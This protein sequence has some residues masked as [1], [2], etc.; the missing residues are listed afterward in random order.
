MQLNNINCINVATSS[1]VA[2]LT[3]NVNME[4][5]QVN[6]WNTV[7]MARFSSQLLGSF[8]ING[9]TDSGAGSIPTRFGERLGPHAIELWKGLRWKKSKVFAREVRCAGADLMHDL[10]RGILW[11][12]FKPAFERHSPQ[13]MQ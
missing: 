8:S 10:A 7:K 3:M 1:L 12:E 6:N 4:N 11:L 2:P 13:V 9:W 5:S